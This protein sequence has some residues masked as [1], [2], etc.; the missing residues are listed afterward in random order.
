MLNNI[1]LGSFSRKNLLRF[2]KKKYLEISQLLTCVRAVPAVDGK[3]MVG[4]DCYDGRHRELWERVGGHVADRRVG[5]EFHDHA[6]VVRQRREHHRRQVEGGRPRRMRLH[7][8]LRRGLAEVLDLVLDGLAHHRVAH[9][10]K[11]DGS[12]V[13][14]VVEHVRRSHGLGS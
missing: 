9:G 8:E 13:R 12:L 11:V 14:Q 6:N 7:Q 1:V 4:R 10:L 3:V 5:Q 2:K